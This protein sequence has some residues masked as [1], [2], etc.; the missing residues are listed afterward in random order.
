MVTNKAV[1][2]KTRFESPHTMGIDDK[3]RTPIMPRP[4]KTA[5]LIKI[6]NGLD[7][8]IRR[9]ESIIADEE[10]DVTI[11]PNSKDALYA[12]FKTYRIDTVPDITVS[13]NGDLY[14]SWEFERKQRKQCLGLSFLSNGRID[15]VLF[16]ERDE[17]GVLSRS[18]GNDT[19]SGIYHTI[20]K[21]NNLPCVKT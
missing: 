5:S 21:A 14:A 19:A 17:P 2:D 20:I 6:I 7:D 10:P 8:E 18:Y 15:F 12:F 11:S 9:M 13:D 1:T 4:S 3:I 16:I